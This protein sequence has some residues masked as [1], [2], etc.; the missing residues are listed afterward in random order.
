[1]SSCSVFVHS[2]WSVMRRRRMIAH[3]ST[4]DTRIERSSDVYAG[5][6]IGPD[7]IGTL[8]RYTASAVTSDRVAVLY[9]AAIG[10]S[11]SSTGSAS[12]LLSGPAPLR[13]EPNLTFDNGSC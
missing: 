12:W 2:F 6:I 3:H 1:M 11:G 13:I 8:S 4:A 5:V 7:Q 9:N 10:R